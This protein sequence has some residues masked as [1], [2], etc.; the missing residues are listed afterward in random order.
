MAKIETGH[1]VYICIVDAS[2]V[3]S[4]RSIS[5]SIVT[6]KRYRDNFQATIAKYDILGNQRYNLFE[7]IPSIFLRFSGSVR[8]NA[9]PQPW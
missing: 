2:R 5:R 7:V 9:I 1:P 8:S 4:F 6:R 3:F